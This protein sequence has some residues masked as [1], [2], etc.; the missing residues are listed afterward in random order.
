MTDARSSSGPAFYPVIPAG[1]SGK[2]LWPL[3][4]ANY[5]KF[6]RPLGAPGSSLLR[7]TLTRLRPL[8]PAEN[9]FVVTS[10]AIAPLVSRE[11]PE[12]PATNILVEPSP[13]DSGPAIALAAA[14]IAAT[15]PEAV[16]GSFA[17]DHVVR[18]PDRLRAAVTIA[19][20]GALNGNLMTV[21]ITPTRPE[22]GFGYIRRGEG[23]DGDRMFRVEEFV[24]KPQ[25]EIAEK[26]VESGEY[27][28]NA[29]FFIWK[30][31]VFLDELR[32][33]EPAFYDGL[34][35]IAD[36]WYTDDREEVLATVWPTLPKKAIEYILLEPAARDG[37]VATVPG[38]FGWSDVGDYHAL[39]EIQDGDENGNV[40]IGVD[41]GQEADHGGAEVM[42]ADCERLVVVSDGSRLITTMGLSDLVIV[43]TPDVLMVCDRS[44]AQDVKKLVEELEKAGAAE[45][46]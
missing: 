3:S 34:Q 44:R 18:Y 31:Q 26:Y 24:E 28:W 20:E 33:R 1:G 5:P 11:L 42:L 43:D 16:M 27:L 14:V 30:V 12:L 15:D 4:R 7:A 19:I 13:R 17:A 38:D 9:I 37:L 46:I 45:Y 21:G 23:I 29:G 41:A 40:V 10:G 39:G 8:A 22:T 2:R 36:A 6:M 35:R 25:L 32:R